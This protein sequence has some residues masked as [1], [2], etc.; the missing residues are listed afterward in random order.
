MET[1][2]KTI[3][4]ALDMRP[5]D[6]STVKAYRVLPGLFAHRNK[7]TGCWSISHHSGYAISCYADTLKDCRRFA[8]EVQNVYPLD[9]TLDAETIGGMATEGGKWVS[10]FRN[11]AE[12]YPVEYDEQPESQRVDDSD[13]SP[14]EQLYWEGEPVWMPDMETVK[15]WV[16]DST[17]EALDGC[18]VE[19]DGYSPNGAPSYL[20]ALG[21]I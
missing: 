12:G 3:D 11:A 20:I 7:H 10:L 5:G 6:E 21:L 14:F 15:R 19:P 4:L 16:Y 2:R 8:S 9:W 17:C 1:S 13:T 18:T